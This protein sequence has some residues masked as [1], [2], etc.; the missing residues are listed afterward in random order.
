METVTQLIGYRGFVEILFSLEEG[1]K[2]FND[3]KR[4]GMSPSTV[5]SRL[6]YA[7]KLGFIRQELDARGSGRSR[8]RYVLTPKGGQV[9]QRFTPIKSK[10]IHLRSEMKV[11]ERTMHERES[12]VKLL[13]ASVST[14]RSYQT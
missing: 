9:V 13:L 4:L 2:G 7:E 11:L 10:F 5:L 6:R 3:L 12:Q 1:R 14:R 8:I